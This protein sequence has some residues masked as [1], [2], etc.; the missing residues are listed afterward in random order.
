MVDVRMNYASMDKMQKEFQRAGEQVSA[1]LDKMLKIVQMME[2][3]ALQGLG[4]DAFKDAIL[5]KL[6]PRM[7]TLM[8]KMME[9]KVDIM[10][11]VMETRDGVKNAKGRFSN[12]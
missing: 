7:N 8:V 12:K 1:S 4:G 6:A 5:A 3:G 11:A 10:L 9:L 2:D